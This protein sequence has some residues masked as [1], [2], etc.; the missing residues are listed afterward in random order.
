MDDVDDTE[1]IEMYAGKV[2]TKKQPEQKVVV[3]ETHYR[4]NCRERDFESEVAE[5][6]GSSI[7]SES[8]PDDENVAEDETVTP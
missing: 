5:P 4:N 7:K 3:E 2:Q 1:E 8:E 6:G